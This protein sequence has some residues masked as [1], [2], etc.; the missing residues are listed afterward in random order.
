MEV[1]LDGLAKR[2]YSEGDVE[3][4]AGKNLYRLYAEVIG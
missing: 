1:V 3:K 4:L 2:G